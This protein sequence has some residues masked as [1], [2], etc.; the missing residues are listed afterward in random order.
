[1]GMLRRLLDCDRRGFQSFLYEN[2]TD[3][4]KI[5]L[6]LGT[7]ISSTQGTPWKNE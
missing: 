3:Y 6:F 5:C 7:S 4:E 1:M 2:G